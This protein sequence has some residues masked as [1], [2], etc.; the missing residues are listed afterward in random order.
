MTEKPGNSDE[1][2]SILAGRARAVEDWVED[3]FIDPHGVV[4]TALDRQT[5]RPL[6][7]SSFDAAVDM[8]KYVPGVAPADFWHY[9]NCGMTT[10]A[11]LQALV[12]R[13]AVTGDAAALARARRS[14]HALRHIYEMGEELEE[15]FFPKIYGGR[16]SNQTSTDQVL[17]AVMALDA[18]APHAAAAERAEIARMISCMI[19]FWVKRKYRYLY[20]H[21][22]DMLWPLARFPSLLLLAYK[23]SGDAKFQDEYRRLLAEGVNRQPGESRLLRKR[24]GAG[25]TSDYEREQHAWLIAH[26]ADAATMDI[27]ELDYLLRHDP[28][29]SWAG[30]WRESVRT[31]WEEGRLAIGDDGTYYIEVLVDMDTG[32]ARRPAARCDAGPRITGASSGWGSMIA[33]AGVQAAAHLAGPQAAIA[34]AKKALAAQDIPDFT[35]MND[36]ERWPPELRYKTKF[37]SGDAVSNWLWA[38]WQGRLAGYWGSEPV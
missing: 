16:F 8:H 25:K 30:C 19:D 29:N 35:Y 15:G 32:A 26:L 1:V 2:N 38:Y 36:P 37:Y 28:Q 18:F 12:C 14:F 21:N 31:M 27:M 7:A 4:Y 22:P 13:H 5:A 9:E 24:S 11:Y 3:H 33:R 10:G 6:T 20:Y 17:Y 23:H 34:I